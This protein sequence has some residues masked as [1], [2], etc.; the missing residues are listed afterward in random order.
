MKKAVGL[1]A[2][3]I[4]TVVARWKESMPQYTIG[5][6]SRMTGMKE[7]FYNE[8]P[9]VR[10]AGSSYEGISIPDCVKQGKEIAEE[11]F[12]QLVDSEIVIS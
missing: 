5:H 8:F 3:P 7:Q 9:N 6:E 12:N 2:S 11:V 1:N 4:L 10:L